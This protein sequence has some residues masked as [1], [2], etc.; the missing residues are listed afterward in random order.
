[1]INQAFENLVKEAEMF[2]VKKLITGKRLKEEYSDCLDI[3]FNITKTKDVSRGILAHNPNYGQGKSFFFDVVSHRHKRLKGK[4]LFVKTTAKD[5]CAIYTSTK[6]GKD[7][8]NALI[9]FISVRNLFIDDI[10]EELKE[11]AF[12]HN[13]ANKLNVLRFVLLKRYELWIEKGWITHGTTNLSIDEI[14]KNY[15]GRVADRLMQMTYFKEFKFLKNGTFRQMAETRKLTKEEIDKSWGLLKKDKPIEKVNLEDYFNSLIKEPDSYFEN[16]GIMFWTFMKDYFVDKKILTDHDF[17]KI[18]ENMI[19][20]TELLL[21]KEARELTKSQ[22]K[23]ATPIVV[24]RRIDESLSNI[25]RLQI[26]EASKNMIVKRK[27]FA[28][29]KEN[30]L[31]K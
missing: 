7:P 21:R 28:L 11:G 1:M 25:T 10:G 4:N 6:K 27:F 8:E 24:G 17:D 22:M 15:D 12:R 19:D 23:H 3:L 9:E 13:Y 16:N 14:A 2:F 5:L 26:Y 20:A 18:D 29:K 31:F 30:H